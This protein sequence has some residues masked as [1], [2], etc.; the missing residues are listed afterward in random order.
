MTAPV[1][2]WDRLPADL[3]RRLD[4]E[5]RTVAHGPH[6]E[7][8]LQS[9]LAE[10]VLIV[11]DGHALEIRRAT[12]TNQASVI[13]VLGPG[14][15]AGLHLLAGQPQRADVVAVGRGA[16]RVLRVPQARFRQLAEEHHAFATA[17]LRTMDDRATHDGLRL[18]LALAP[19]VG[20]DQRLA[21]HLVELAER[22]G[23]PHGGGALLDIGLTQEDL[24]R[25]AGVTRAR[26]NR[27]LSRFRQKGL[28]D[29]HWRRIT[30]LPG[31][32]RI[33]EPFDDLWSVTPHR[34]PLLGE[35][36]KP[37]LRGA[38]LPA[39]LAWPRP[40]SLPPE[41]RHFTGRAAELSLLRDELLHS[42]GQRLAV[43]HGPSGSGKS[44][45]AAHFAHAMAEHFPDGRIMVDVRGRPA[46]TALGAILRALGLPGE[47]VPRGEESLTEL[48]RRI[49]ADRDLLL[50]FDDAEGPAQIRRLLP[51]TPSCAVVVT[52]GEALPS[53]GG[54]QIAVGPLAEDEAADLVARIA[55]SAPPET[56]REVARLCERNPLA[57]R[58]AAAR[59]E[60]LADLQAGTEA[61]G[62][63]SAFMVAYRGLAE[64]HRH[65]FRFASLTPSADFSE[66]SLSALVGL[67][68]AAAGG[69][70]EALDALAEAGLVTRQHA[71]R[72]RWHALLR[73]FALDRV[74]LENTQHERDGAVDRVLTYFL[75][76]AREH[77]DRLGRHRRAFHGTGPEPS[78]PELRDRGLAWF[79]RE[80]R[81]LVAAARLAA[82]AGRHEVAYG[83]ADACFDFLELRRYG[84]STIDMHRIGLRSARLADDP[85]AVAHMLRN[86]GV[87][88][89][90]VGEYMEAFAYAKMAGRA[91]ADLEDR[92]G[93]A[94]VEGDLAAVHQL[95]DQHDAAIGSAWRSLELYRDSRDRRGEADVL[96]RLGES[97][98]TLGRYAESL[99][100]A[101]RALALHRAS[102]DARGEA[103][104]LRIRANIRH[105]RREHEAAHRDA[106]EALALS[107][108]RH[109][110]TGEARALT[111]LAKVGRHLRLHGEGRE[112][113]RKAV[114]L[115]L[116]SGDRQA[117]G[118][119]RIWL[120]W[121]LLDE[122]DL[123]GALAQ[124]DAGLRA[125]IEIDHPRGQ[126]SARTA[127]AIVLQQRGRLH[128]SR[129][130][131]EQALSLARRIGDRSGEAQALEEMA[132]TLRRLHQLRDARTFG[133][134]AL[135]AW[136]R[137]GH[138]HGTAT[139]HGG[140]ARIHLLAGEIDAALAACDQAE[141]LRDHLGDRVG[142]GRVAD[143]RARILLRMGEYGRALKV[144]EEALPL[145]RSGGAPFPL[146]SALLVRASV[147]LELRRYGDAHK[148]AVDGLRR[149]EELGDG[150]AEAEAR[151]V[152]GLIQQRQGG[153]EGALEQ[154]RH[155]DS[156][157]VD[158][159]D[160]GGR[161]AVL[162]AQALSHERLGGH[163]EADRCR[164]TAH[165]LRRWLA[166]P[167]LPGG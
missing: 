29:A 6:A 58:V 132:T 76:G 85:R 38:A 81:G 4:A 92:H 112:H 42:P 78:A 35:P 122:A 30:D 164:R 23:R 116:A 70:R 97:L 123:D 20:A 44:A 150:A 25:Y 139:A 27:T 37:R 106:A 147:L 9:R 127:I 93:Q 62:V 152:L 66:E 117:E 67:P 118:W 121:T 160:Q 31:L 45:L 102:G 74:R 101:E 18:A 63:R 140:L 113:G 134:A 100:E 21:A 156:V 3:Q 22:F 48:Y 68:V 28:L 89:L 40:P 119:A 7:L 71:G 103:E 136:R 95:L 149:A 114:D 131:L 73:Q 96:L 8:Q 125:H 16:M 128:E 87:V 19:E 159:D 80:L 69:V 108:A 55:P 2:F 50:V 109:D 99:E 133:E 33:A 54:R 135:A 53:L 153:D 26:T 146:A 166:R 13:G 64:E 161:I 143:T 11:R 91:F 82:E 88:H 107:V 15:G 151:L 56:R 142:L 12:L 124:L 10:D 79:E 46:A 39:G 105:G 130:Q 90:A 115:A 148:Q 86:L 47:K 49:V 165:E 77:G 52:S 137:L 61:A 120:G 17:V 32:R 163:D 43:L 5:H 111:I 162:L 158:V 167:E 129:S 145:M 104:A 110:A 51:M 72:Y 144:I 157:L 34:R 94:V 60:G 154:F 1:S 24:G 36:A 141:A 41:V 83:L 138:P 59:P 65:V 75:D 84:R 155:A 98:C 14:D 126:V 57:V